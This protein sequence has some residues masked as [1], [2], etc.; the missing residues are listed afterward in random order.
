MK[1]AYTNYKEALAIGPINISATYIYEQTPAVVT[2]EDEHLAVNGLALNLLC[3]GTGVAYDASQ[4]QAYLPQALQALAE[5]EHDQAVL[6]EALFKP[7]HFSQPLTRVEALKA[8]D[9]K[10]PV[11]SIV[12]DLGKTVAGKIGGVILDEI[13]NQIFPQ[14]SIADLLQRFINELKEYIHTELVTLKLEDVESDI[15]TVI[16]FVNNEYLPNRNA[17]WPKRTYYHNKLSKQHDTLSAAITRLE[18]ET[19]R[20][21]GFGLYVLAVP[22]H[23]SILQELAL[24]DPL[25]ISSKRSNY[26]KTLKKYR[27]GY[28][29][30]AEKTWNSILQQRRALIRC[31]DVQAGRSPSAGTGIWSSA[32]LMDNFPK[33]PKKIEHFHRYDAYALDNCNQKRF[34]VGLQLERDLAVAFSGDTNINTLFDNWRKAPDV[35]T[36]L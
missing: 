19:V 31:E 18:G 27:D 8:D 12:K 33:P 20:N 15:K 7:A 30:E 3:E 11:G 17:Y 36:D 1:S 13:F 23:L 9:T 21:D 34:T 2:T 35:I 10:D 5:S 6:A 22:L 32:T 4:P 16:K 26:L 25:V 29:A 24:T 14:E 28:I